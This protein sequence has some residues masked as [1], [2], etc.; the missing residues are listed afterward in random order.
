MGCFRSRWPFSNFVLFGSFKYDKTLTNLKEG[1]GCPC[2][3]HIKL[4]VVDF[5]AVNAF[6]LSFEENF[7]NALPTGSRNT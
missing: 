7:G 5:S 4:T 3:G 6:I 1:K 2:A